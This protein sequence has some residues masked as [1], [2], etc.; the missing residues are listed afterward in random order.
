MSISFLIL[1]LY[2]NQNKYWLPAGVVPTTNYKNYNG[3]AL[4]LTSRGTQ[5][6][7]TLS[8]L[9]LPFKITCSYSL[10]NLTSL[11]STWSGFFVRQ[12]VAEA[13]DTNVKSFPASSSCSVFISLFIKTQVARLNQP[14][15]FKIHHHKEYQSW[16]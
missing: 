4:W 5:G 8:H 7:L 2:Y 6:K 10:F 9:E 12:Q 11:A 13:S 16:L 3:F 1:A 14:L 15:P